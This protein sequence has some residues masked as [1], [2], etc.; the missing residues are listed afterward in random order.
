[1]TEKLGRNDPCHCKSGK[2]YKKCH[3]HH[4]RIAWSIRN[5]PDILEEPLE[6]MKRKQL[7]HLKFQ[8]T[9]GKGKD[10]I[11]TEWQGKRVVAVGSTVHISPIDKT[12]SFHDFLGNF[13]E[14]ELG[15]DWGNEE[16]KKPLANRHIVLQWYD[17]VRKLKKNNKTAPSEDGIYS[18]VRDGPAGAYYNLAY[19]LY[20]IRHNAALKDEFLRRLRVPLQFQGARYEL[21]VAATFVRAGFEI[22][23]EDERDGSKK[24]PEFTATH[25]ET[26]QIIAVEAKS[27][28]RSGIL[29]HPG[30]TQSEGKIRAR[31]G[32]LLNEA[33]DKSPPHPYVIFMDV[34][35][36]P[37]P[38][39][40]EKKKT[41]WM[42]E[43]NA[44]QAFRRPKSEKDPFN[45]IIFTN[46]P[47]HFGA[48]GEPDPPLEAC[49]LVAEKPK[50][51]M[52]NPISL[53]AVW[54]AIG[55]YGKI[56]KD[57]PKD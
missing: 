7:D 10:I 42:D 57:F 55:L 32:T 46:Q 19:H 17:S 16:L 8:N 13:I 43:I 45:M 36:P 52:A 44:S 40:R 37:E 47:H 3:W 41:R 20:L 24:H 6:A 25:L 5:N 38:D 31:I 9:Y 18:A 51:E 35:F 29:G 34:N 4:D 15:V 1:V 30:K 21:F 54:D 39:V 53:E 28:H 26:G 22:N 49:R 33:F 14:G 2:K 48:E 11:S 50:I 12:K 27:K 23:F 56:P